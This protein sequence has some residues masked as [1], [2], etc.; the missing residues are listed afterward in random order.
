LPTSAGPFLRNV[1]GMT[2][3]DPLTVAVQWGGVFVS[4]DDPAENLPALPRHLLEVA[5]T[6][7][8][9]ESF[10]SN[11]YFTTEFVGNGPFKLVEWTP[12]VQIELAAFDDYYRGRPRL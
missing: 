8:S 1:Q 6:A 9:P 10:G 5:L 4:A 3:V 2:K 12:G 7:R 11:P